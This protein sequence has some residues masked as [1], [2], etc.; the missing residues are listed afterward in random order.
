MLIGV[1]LWMALSAAS[2]GMGGILGESMRLVSIGAIVLG[3][4]HLLESVLDSMV[5]LSTDQNE[6]IHRS[7]ILVGFVLLSLGLRRIGELRRR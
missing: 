4:A 6:F 1:S 2:M 3:L 5:H 7:M